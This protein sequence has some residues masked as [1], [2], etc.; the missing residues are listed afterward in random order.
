MAR[1]ERTTA[2]PRPHPR[3]REV[4]GRTVLGV[5]WDARRQRM[6]ILGGALALL[7]FVVGA[8]AFR[9]YEDNVGLPNATVLSVGSDTFSLRYYTER[10]SKF[11]R[12]TSSSQAAS[13]NLGI[14]E[15][16]LLSKLEDEGLT[17][18]LA[19]ANGITITNDEINAAMGSDIGLPS[20]GSVALFD[21]LYRQMLKT[22][23]MGDGTYRKLSTAFVANQKLVDLF[24]GQVGDTGE[25][26]TLRAVVVDSKDA[27][28]AL[29]PRI[30]A[31]EDMGTIAQTTSLD[32]S[33][34]TDG[35]MAAQ[36]PLLLP[37]PVQDAI[38]GKQAGANVLGPIQV[39]TQF[40]V[41]RVEKRDPNGSVNSDMKQQLGQA[42]L[43]SSLNDRRQQ[44]KIVRSLSTSDI[45][46]AEA[47]VK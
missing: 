21:Q 34:N 4:S 13:P 25:L 8:L 26:V 32:D 47:H 37:L 40:W 14:T 2:L 12:D 45:K 3:G 27:A 33:R 1:R 17:V 18:Q 20:G 15:Q 11:V 10:L 35:L 16:Q 28:D 42:K 31:G 30:A 19:K 6:A 46:W 41:F 43:D 24:A 5:R 9:I 23:N 38:A 7:V 29:L 39:D 44:T 22:N 36:P